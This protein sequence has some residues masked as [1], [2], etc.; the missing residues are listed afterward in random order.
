M[1]KLRSE[2]K[3]KLDRKSSLSCLLNAT[4]PII[5]VILSNSGGNYSFSY[6]LITPYLDIPYDHIVVCSQMS[7]VNIICAVF[8]PAFRNLPKV[9][10]I[11]CLF[12]FDGFYML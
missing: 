6:I 8:I 4:P 3:I 9:S 10:S 7:S 5:L 1:S 11:L 12:E 2:K